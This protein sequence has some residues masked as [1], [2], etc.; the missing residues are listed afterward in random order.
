[1]R[2]ATIY[3][4]TNAYIIDKVAQRQ[5]CTRG[6]YTRGAHCRETG[7]KDW[8]DDHVFAKRHRLARG[9]E[10]VGARDL[11]GAGRRPQRVQHH[12]G[13]DVGAL[14]RS[15]R[16]EQVV[17]ALG[18][19]LEPIQERQLV[20]GLLDLFLKLDQTIFLIKIVLE[21]I[22]GVAPVD[23]VRAVPEAALADGVPASLASRTK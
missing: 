3:L 2:C 5:C 7:P 11:R 17:D 13:V 20:L 23:L 6:A 1:M 19:D 15:L 21:V 9:R 22:I 18:L 16:V 12:M 10:Q 8:P 4:T 14:D